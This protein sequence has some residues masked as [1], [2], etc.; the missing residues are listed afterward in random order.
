[1]GAGTTKKGKGEGGKRLK[2]KKLKMV[3]VERQK[4]GY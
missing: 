3:Y 2:K 1:L 4:K